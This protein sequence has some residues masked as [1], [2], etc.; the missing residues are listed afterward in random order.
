MIIDFMFLILLRCFM[1]AE[2]WERDPNPNELFE[3]L[4]TKDHDKVTYIDKKSAATAVSLLSSSLQYFNHI[5][6]W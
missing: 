6:N 3:Y 2:E 5:N 1:Q 4:H